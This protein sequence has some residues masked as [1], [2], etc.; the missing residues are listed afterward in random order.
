MLPYL[1]NK[2]KKKVQF[3]N[4]SFG[5]GKP[6]NPLTFDTANLIALYNGD[7]LPTDPA[8]SWVDQSA[9]GFDLTLVNGPGIVIGAINNHF[10]LRFNGINQRG[11]TAAFARNQPTTVYIVFRNVVL[12]NGRIIDGLAV[13]TNIIWTQAL[14]QINIFAGTNLIQAVANILIY[15]IY[16][17]VYNG[18]TSENRI[19]NAAALVGNA[20]AGNASG[21]TVGSGAGGANLCNCE[22]AYL[23]LRQGADSTATQ[24]LFINYLKNRFA[25]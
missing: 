1:K 12:N 3:L 22:I 25:L 14:N 8:G 10:A 4:K 13:D 24:N 6:F 21:L 18:V 17:G 19:N 9:N 7:T 2:Y 23:I 5:L 11:F 15:D 20:G 16:T